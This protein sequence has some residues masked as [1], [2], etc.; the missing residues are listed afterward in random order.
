MKYI[1]TLFLTFLLIGCASKYRVQPDEPLLPLNDNE[2]YLGLVYD[3]LDPLK[4]IQLKHIDSGESF[5]VGNADK[6]LSQITLKLTEGEYCFIGFDV[7]NLRV[8]YTEQGFCTYVEAGELNYFAE[9]IVR[10]P[11]T[12]SQLSYK[13]YIYLLKNDLP[14]LCQEFV[15]KDC[16]L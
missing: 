16:E 7:Y 15:N 11:V 6:G 4:T 3:T 9:F 1:S 13:R 12:I 8:D 5:Y 14:E 10:N 2:G